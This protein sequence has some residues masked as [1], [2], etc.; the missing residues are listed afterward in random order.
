MECFCWV[1]PANEGTRGGIR[2]IQKLLK[3]QLWMTMDPRNR[4]GSSGAVY[5]EAFGSTSYLLVA[6]FV[7]YKVVPK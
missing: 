6:C 7:S 3:P 5:V 1:D 2:G 4:K